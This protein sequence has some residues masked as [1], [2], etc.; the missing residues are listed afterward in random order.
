MINTNVE[1]LVGMAGL[2][3]TLLVRYSLGE[4][5]L[6][7]PPSIQYGSRD[8]GLEAIYWGL[9]SGLNGN[10]NVDPTGL[11]LAMQHTVK[12]NTVHYSI[13]QYSTDEY[14]TQHNTVQYTPLESF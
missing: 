2:V 5:G 1:E 10:T 8:A 6:E 13:V 14:R 3:A 7:A 12:W 4:G 11:Y 9:V